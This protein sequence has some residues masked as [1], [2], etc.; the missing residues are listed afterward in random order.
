MKAGF[1]SMFWLAALLVAI[2]IAGFVSSAASY[3]GVP[4]HESLAGMVSTRVPIAATGNATADGE[5]NSTDERVEEPSMSDL[6]ALAEE[7]L[8]DM[9]LG[10]RDYTA[11]LIKRERINGKL[12]SE[13]ELEIKIRERRESDPTQSDGNTAGLAA[14]LKFIE[15][16]SARGREVIWIENENDNKLTVHE[17]GFKNLLRLE[18]APDSTLAMLGNK[19]PITEIGLRR[20]VEKLVEKC[21]R[22][23]DFSQCR[24][25]VIENQ[26][27]GDRSCRLI[28]VTQPKSVPGADFYI[29][30]VFLDMERKLPLRYAAFLWPEEEG[31]PPPLEEEYTY[32][33]LEL[34]VGLTDADFDADNPAYAFP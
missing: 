30:Q 5:H 6:V 18:L 2:T 15:P 1:Y 3:N 29:A 27:V 8:G 32:L 7:M 22:E 28:Q 14:Y 19:Y 11:K 10:V 9:R 16:R 25:E 34:N 23:V 12:G 20:L 4:P 33:D 26:Q 21:T 31:Q 24:V 13:V 17:G